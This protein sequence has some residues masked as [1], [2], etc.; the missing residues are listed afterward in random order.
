MV[1]E[2]MVRRAVIRQALRNRSNQALIFRRSRFL[3][4]L[5]SRFETWTPRGSS[6][7]HLNHLLI[8]GW[9]CNVQVQPQAIISTN[10]DS[11]G[12]TQISY[13]YSQFAV[14]WSATSEKYLGDI[15][16]ASTA[17]HP[18]F[19]N[20]ITTPTATGLNNSPSVFIQYLF[21]ACSY[22]NGV[23]QARLH[24]IDRRRCQSK[25]G[26]Q[27]RHLPYIRWDRLP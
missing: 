9:L 13:I 27:E 14:S 18:I 25:V 16:P 22:R 23:A 15:W 2:W 4:P 8:V 19:Q 1:I 6:R 17:L 21:L 3:I 7:D 24:V 5:A 26:A 12:R 20:D 10:Q 11:G